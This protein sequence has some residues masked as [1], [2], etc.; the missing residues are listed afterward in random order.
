MKIP[1]ILGALCFLLLLGGVSASVTT[2]TTV[3]YVE[4]WEN[5]YGGRI[6]WTIDGDAANQLKNDLFMNYDENHDGKMS[7]ANIV[8]Y[9]LNIKLLLINQTM[10]T[11]EITDAQPL[12][13]WYN[14][15]EINRD[16]VSGIWNLN[17]T[18]KIVIKMR[19][20]GIPLT[21]GSLNSLNLSKV[22]FA[23]ALRTNLT[24]YT[25]FNYK[26]HRI[27]SEIGA[28]FSSYSRIP[29]AI[30]LRLVVGE[31]FRYDGAPPSNENI[32]RI[33]FSFVDSPLILFVILLVFTKAATWIERRSY[34]KHIRE[35][36]TFG[37][38][39]KMS[40]VMNTLKIILILI[41]ILAVMYYIQ[42]NGITYMIICIVYFVGVAIGAEKLYSSKLPSQ[43]QGILMVE[44][45]FLLSKSGLMISHETRRLKP[46][47]DEDVIS[48]ML[49]AIQDF[50]RTSFKDE[51][52]VEL[53]T[54]E[55]GDKKIFLQRGKYLILAA[56]M[57]GDIDSFVEYRM[58]ETL[59][60]IE[61]E[62]ASILKD[63]KGDVEK[64]RGVR[65]ILK[66]IWE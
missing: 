21:E 45:V 19:V 43:K 36:S 18:D 29:H 20:D 32:D 50:V 9:L 2:E 39:K 33:G 31:Y 38:K 17:T 47:V 27:H 59:E 34:D 11:I 48:S 56:I 41:Y 65:D 35:G 51:G 26:I 5:Y 3:E 60:E 10:G 57:R 61:K 6:T 7:M 55:F 4:I 30:L 40:L 54:I 28:T 53:K 8:S 42:I 24:N 22:P 58:K 66:K 25:S 52:D 14:G 64:F 63:W 23:A 15:R 62:Y 44:D 49:V 12:H 1:V 13:G 37:R 46:E 16:D